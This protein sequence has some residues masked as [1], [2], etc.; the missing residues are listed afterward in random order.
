MYAQIINNQELFTWLYIF[1]IREEY[2]LA[3]AGKI[4]CTKEDDY[5]KYASRCDRPS[6]MQI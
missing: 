1:I 2:L 3:I 4:N 5:E 6:T